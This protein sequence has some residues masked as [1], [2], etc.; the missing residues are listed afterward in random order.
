MSMRI[1]AHLDTGALVAQTLDVVLELSGLERG[2]VLIAPAGE[3]LRVRA[4]RGISA[5]DLSKGSFSGSVA[6][7][8]QALDRGEAVVCCDTNDSP[9]LGLRPSVRLGG[10]RALVCLPLQISDGAR[11]AVY[12]D[13][14]KPGPPVTELDL[15]LIQSVAQ[16]ASAAIT[17][18]RLQ[19]EVHKLMASGDLDEIAP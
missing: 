8:D 16:H 14:R 3:P 6:S 2:F 4:C 1:T 19:S 13:S 15:E 12:V 7:V 10:I 5:S 18:G 9:W 17:A 11:G